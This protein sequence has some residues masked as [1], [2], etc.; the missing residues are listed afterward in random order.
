MNK[1]I[2]ALVAC[3]GLAAITGCRK[4]DTPEYVEI[5]P[6][7]TAF[8]VPME[9]VTAEQTSFESEEYLRKNMVAAKRVQVPHRWNKTG[10]IW[11]SGNWMDTLRVIVVDR[12]PVNRYWTNE[13]NGAIQVETNDSVSLS[14]DVTC[15]AMIEQENTPLFLYRY[16]AGSLM[17]V[18]DNEIRAKIQTEL[19]EAVARKSLEEVKLN[20]GEIME[21]VRPN[22]TRFFAD[23]GVTIT[24]L[25]FGGGLNYL[26]P[27]IQEAIDKT[28]QDQQLAI[29]AEAQ[30]QAQLKTNETIKITADAAAAAARLK[31]QGEADAIKMLAD[32]KAYEIE[33]MNANKDQYIAL[34]QL[35]NMNLLIGR[36]NGTMPVYNMS[37]GGSDSSLPSI[38]MN[39]PSPTA[40]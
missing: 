24:T 6:N 16:P 13:Q 21:V 2:F 38:L 19:T 14:M 17:T 23:R 28:V 40:K 31:A 22:V 39:L 12:S 32:A 35:E 34:R 27:K 30:Y 5:K 3:V 36:W 8:A 33:K 18:M 20:K 37:M 15:T 29:S 25:G 7:E 4:Y 11:L 10:R 26:N 9:G 1:K